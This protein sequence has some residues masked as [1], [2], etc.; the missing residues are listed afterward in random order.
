MMPPIFICENNRKSIK[1]MHC[2]EFFLSGSFGDKAVFTTPTQKM[3]FFFFF[4]TQCI[5]LLLFLLFSQIKIGGG[6]HFEPPPCTLRNF[7]E[8]YTVKLFIFYIFRIF[9]MVKYTV[10]PILFS[11][12]LYE[13]GH[14]FL[15]Y[16]SQIS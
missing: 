3:F 2:V 5:I 6:G 16:G 9:C 7:F 8:F 4:S 15:E 11:K 1:I 10:W 12:L 14:Y 13:I